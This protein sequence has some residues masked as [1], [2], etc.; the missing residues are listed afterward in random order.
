MEETGTFPPATSDR[1]DLNVSLQAP[2]Q[3][4]YS[5]E[6]DYSLDVDKYNLDLVETAAT[7][8]SQLHQRDIFVIEYDLTPLEFCPLAGELGFNAVQKHVVLD[9]FISSCKKTK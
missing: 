2:W 4:Q 9:A 1:S 5:G 3:I 6:M 7:T 8:I